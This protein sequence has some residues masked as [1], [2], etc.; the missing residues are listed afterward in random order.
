MLRFFQLFLYCLKVIFKKFIF[1]EKFL[2]SNNIR[3][4]PLTKNGHELEGFSKPFLNN[5]ITKKSYFVR[6]FNTNF[7][8]LDLINFVLDFGKDFLFKYE[9][10]E[11]KT[12]K[13]IS[14]LN[15]DEDFLLPIASF[16]KKNEHIK[17][18]YK[19][20]AILPN[21]FIYLPCKKKKDYE[22]KSEK[23]ILIGSPLFLK[24]NNRNKYRL[25]ISLFVD[26]LSFLKLGET[27]FENYCP[28]IK[29]YFQSGARF[30]NNFCNAE[31]TLPSYPSHFTGLRQQNH[32]FYNNKKP[33]L[34]RND[35]K[36]LP[37]LFQE[38]G[39]NTLFLN[40]SP[41]ANPKYGYV[42]GFNR[43]IHKIG[44]SFE[45]ICNDL[46][47][48]LSIFNNRDNFV[49]INLNE[50]HLSD[51]TLPSFFNQS[52]LKLNYLNKF[53]RKGLTSKSQIKE[54]SYDYDE[55]EVEKYLIEL[56]RIDRIFERFLS[57]I[58][59]YAKDEEI[60]ISLITD[61]GNPFTEK[62]NDLLS[63]N[64]MQVP[65][66]INSKD[67]KSQD[68][69]DFTENV[70]SFLS[71]IKLCDLNPD[72]NKNANFK[73]HFSGENFTDCILPKCF[74]GGKKRDF[75]FIQSIYDRDPYFAKVLD[76]EIEYTLTSDRI[77]EKGTINIDKI[78]KEV[79][80]SNKDIN[81]NSDKI[82]KYE[83]F[84]LE[85]INNWNVSI[86]ENKFK[87]YEN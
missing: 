55:T 18:N 10:L 40:S 27:D 30:R 24:N 78:K 61:H 42:R 6:F 33:H 76:N 31:W 29:R 32:G 87:F 67:I 68:I 64:R 63:K 58:K 44:Y 79:K 86:K 66:M 21:K 5:H 74:G 83:K 84:C 48:H 17:I 7:E 81:D 77:S 3:W 20:I 19:D 49:L 39:Y 82:K 12:A 23:N 71:M 75:V 69:Y 62:T 50:L 28:N 51:K 80:I 34:F 35:I 72:G 1:K 45:E 22:I 52:K 25:V 16:S 15:Y 9:I 60:L 46:D 73:N 11:A 56:T 47:E 70:D 65:W 38:K 8:K 41:R 54:K 14:N 43:T 37:E 85:Q 36:V 57:I 53:Y 26:G 13:N 4:F 59:N 2:G